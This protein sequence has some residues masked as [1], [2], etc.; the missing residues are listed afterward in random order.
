M[1][2]ASSPL[3]LI[4]DDDP[5]CR[6]LVAEVLDDFNCHVAPSADQALQFFEHGLRF[7]FLL[8]DVQMPGINGI[9]FCRRALG[10]QPSLPFAMMSGVQDFDVMRSAMQLGASDFLFKPFVLDELTAAVARAVGD[11]SKEAQWRSTAE[12]L[13]SALGLKNVETGGHA[14]RVAY[15]SVMLGKAF[16]LGPRTLLDLEL[17][18]L[19]HDVGKIGVPDAVLRKPTRLDAE[20]ERLMRRHPLYGQQ[21]LRQFALP[22]AVVRVAHQHH[23]MIDGLGYPQGLRGEEIDLLARILGVTDAFDAMTSDRAYRKALSLEAALAEIERCAGTQFDREVAS[24]FMAVIP[25]N[26][27][28]AQAGSFNSGAGAC[29]SAARVLEEVERHVI[30]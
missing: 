19:L 15:W 18:A 28:P 22:E 16:N 21:I 10:A 27:D 29:P 13:T 4:V 3:L 2:A 11:V 23:E 6:Q 14:K 8:S 24:V 1:V 9:E 30:V 5:A 25:N 26:F 7:D 20:E 17:G 12:A